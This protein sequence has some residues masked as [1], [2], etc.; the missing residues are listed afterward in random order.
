MSAYLLFVGDPRGRRCEACQKPLLHT[1]IIYEWRGRLYSL[2]CF[3]DLLT[4]IAPSD[5]YAYS[6]PGADW[7]AP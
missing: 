5:P 7:Q 4:A 6:P 3:L 2:S 1:D